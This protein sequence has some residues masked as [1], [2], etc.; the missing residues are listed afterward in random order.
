MIKHIAILALWGKLRDNDPRA[1][2]AI[3][4]GTKFSL[5]RVEYDIA[6][7]GNLFMEKKLALVGIIMGV[8]KQGRKNYVGKLR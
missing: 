6:I 1:A 5:H 3:F 8:L 7:V 2:F 4:D